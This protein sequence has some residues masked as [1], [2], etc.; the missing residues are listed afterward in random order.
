MTPYAR[1]LL[2]AFDNVDWPCFE[3]EALRRIPVMDTPLGLRE[4]PAVTAAIDELAAAGLI[5][6]WRPAEDAPAD[7]P[8]PKMCLRRYWPAGRIWI[9]GASW[10][11]PY[12][13]A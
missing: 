5:A 11:G 8:H 4:G 7:K 9:R 1:A 6:E 2:L 10:R 3:A 13:S 12:R